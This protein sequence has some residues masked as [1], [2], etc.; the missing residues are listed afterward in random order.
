MKGIIAWLIGV[1]IVV[2]VLLYLSDI[3]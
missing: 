2:I 3:F 1:P